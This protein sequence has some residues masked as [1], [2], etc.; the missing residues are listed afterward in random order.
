MRNSISNHQPHDCL[1]NRLFKR[2]SKKTSKLCVTGLCAG[3]FRGPVNS[4]HKWRVTRKMFPT[5]D[6]IINC[7]A[8]NGKAKQGTTELRTYGMGYSGFF[9]SDNTLIYIIRASIPGQQVRRLTARATAPTLDRWKVFTK[10]ILL[11]QLPYFQV[12]MVF[13]FSKYPR[14]PLPTDVVLTRSI[15]PWNAVRF[16][17]ISSAILKDVLWSMEFLYDILRLKRWLIFF[18]NTQGGFAQLMSLRGRI[19]CVF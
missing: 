8:R 2:R 9:L 7:A 4:P 13:I 15:F 1:L 18:F 12:L 3:I 6:V 17:D 5:D 14:T 19:T 11:L 16:R 10:E